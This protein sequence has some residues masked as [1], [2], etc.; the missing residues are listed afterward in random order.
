MF[1]IRT[2]IGNYIVVTE[3]S[4]FP[5]KGWHTYIYIGDYI[6]KLLF[7]RNMRE[8]GGTHLVIKNIMKMVNDT[9]KMVQHTLVR[10]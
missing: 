3:P 4:N 7:S 1:K 6:N 10:P 2:K 8:A 5:L 9:E